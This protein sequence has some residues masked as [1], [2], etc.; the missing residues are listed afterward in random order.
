MY[1]TVC[2]DAL[3]FCRL[4]LM[5]RVSDDGEG[6]RKGEEEEEEEREEE[7]RK[8]GRKE[9]KERQEERDSLVGR[10]EVVVVVGERER[11]REREMW[12]RWQTG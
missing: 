11:E 12:G 9:R 4:R 1:V 7:G 8:E 3:H 10:K 5:K 6:R 2:H